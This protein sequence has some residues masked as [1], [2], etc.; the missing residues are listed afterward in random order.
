MFGCPTD[1][2]ADHSSFVAAWKDAITANVC[3]ATTTREAAVRDFHVIFLSDATATF[4]MG[5]VSAVELHRATLTTLG[6]LFAE[7][8]TADE[9]IEQIS[10][11]AGVPEV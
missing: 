8:I 7:V 3:C 1:T 9:V 6:F 2:Q 10:R 5:G 4:T 11:R